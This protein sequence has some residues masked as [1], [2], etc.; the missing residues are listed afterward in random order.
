MVQASLA[1]PGGG[2]G[3]L[4]LLLPFLHGMDLV[5]MGSGASSSPPSHD[6]GFDSG[7]LF[8]LPSGA[9]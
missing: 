2:A 4:G 8:S 9:G 6:N 5:W 1:P 7:F 3:R